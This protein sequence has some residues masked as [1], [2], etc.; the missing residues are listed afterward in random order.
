MDKPVMKVVAD[1]LT[2]QLA[3]L[4]PAQIRA[5][6]MLASGIRAREVSAALKVAPET[7]SR[8]RQTIPE[9]EALINLF[10]Q[11]TIDATRAGLHDL[12]A[13]ATAELGKLLKSESEATRIKAIQLI[14]DTVT[15]RFDMKGPDGYLMTDPDAIAESRASS[16]RMSELIK[17][18]TRTEKSP[19]SQY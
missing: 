7:V 15:A 13:Q 9:F 6:G 5:A 16:A 4:S 17:G 1:K 8:W 14:F 18:L 10:V 19:K 3:A 2:L 12:S 11:E